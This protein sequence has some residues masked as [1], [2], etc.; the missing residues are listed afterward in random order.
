MSAIS[1]APPRSSA[2]TG[3]PSSPARVAATPTSSGSGLGT[4]DAAQDRVRA[5]LA[6]DVPLVLDAD[7][8]AVGADAIRGRTAPTLLTPHAGEFRRLTG[9]DPAGTRWAR[10]SRP[11]TTS[12]SRSCSR[13]AARSSRRRTGRA[14]ILRTGC[15][16][17]STAGTGDVLGGAAGALL[18]ALAKRGVDDSTLAL[19]PVLPRATC[20]GS[21]AGS[22][23]TG[24]AAGSRRPA[25][26][27]GRRRPLGQSHRLT[28]PAHPRD[29]STRRV[30]TKA[31]RHAAYC[32][33]WRMGRMGRGRWGAGPEKR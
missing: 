11:P 16:W 18:A 14:I 15:P 2:T 21:P 5:L 1:A 31:S 24:R 6:T 12:E 4:D 29:C 22:R 19:T 9:V 33:R 30:G 17:L 13:V 28:V 25:P 3:R 23:A 32:S 20:T 8:L 7:G 27:M 26:G 10:R